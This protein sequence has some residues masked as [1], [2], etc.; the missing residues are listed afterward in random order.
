MVPVEVPVVV[1][2]LEPVVEPVVEAVALAD[3]LA[4]LD[5]DVDTEEDTVVDA[6][7]LTEDDAVEVW[8]VDGVV[9]E[10]HMTG[11]DDETN[12]PRN[13]SVH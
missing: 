3:E 5:A 13:S 9:H 2:E 6:V 4:V 12:S 10:P 8:V 7:E 11:Q 1:L